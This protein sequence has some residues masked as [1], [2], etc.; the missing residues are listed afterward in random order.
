LP[1]QTSWS[2]QTRSLR[3]T[4]ASYCQATGSD[5]SERKVTLG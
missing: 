2:N 5:F 1:T 3:A 4:L